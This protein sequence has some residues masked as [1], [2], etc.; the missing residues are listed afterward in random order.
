MTE[1]SKLG[2]AHPQ[3]ASFHFLF[4][5]PTL[6]TPSNCLLEAH[7]QDL[8]NQKFSEMAVTFFGLS[9]KPPNFDHRQAELGGND[10]S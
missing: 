5:K 2:D 7:F 3:T 6:Q 8:W 4:P 9:A 1:K 10:Y